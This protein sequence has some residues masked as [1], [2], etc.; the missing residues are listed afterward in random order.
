MNCLIFNQINISYPVNK[1]KRI[2][3]TDYKSIM[4][5]FYSSWQMSVNNLMAVK[6]LNLVTT[7]L[8]FILSRQASSAA[9]IRNW[10]CSCTQLTLTVAVS[11]TEMA[12]FWSETYQLDS[13]QLNFWQVS[14]EGS[15]FVYFS[16]YERG[17]AWHVLVSTGFLWLENTNSCP[18][19]EICSILC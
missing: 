12:M 4:P 5:T 2:K 16:F 15:C 9:V 13:C 6:K 3:K 8:R 10:K 7:F 19:T 11:Q 18:T 14:W 17:Y 1:K